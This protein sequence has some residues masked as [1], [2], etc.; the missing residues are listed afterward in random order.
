MS[1]LDNTSFTV[2]TSAVTTT[3]TNNDSVILII[4]ALGAVTVNLPSVDS[5]QPGRRYYIY[6]DAAA[7]T[8]TI[9]PAGAETIDAGANTTLLTGQVHAKQVIS[10][11]TAW[12]TI[13]EYDALAA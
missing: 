5:V 4:G 10:D 12:F 9:E 3:A 7:Q 6:K 8:I 1:G 13:G 11:G 2:R